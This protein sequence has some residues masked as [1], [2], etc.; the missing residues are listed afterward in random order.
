MSRFTL[1]VAYLLLLLGIYGILFELYSPGALVP[2]LTGVLSL[3]LA[4]YALHLLPVSFAGAALLLVGIAQV[5]MNGFC[6]CSIAFL[7]G[8]KGFFQGYRNGRMILFGTAR[9]IGGNH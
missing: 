8:R 3:L 9:P 5:K 7:R 6:P 1:Y 4:L 2:G